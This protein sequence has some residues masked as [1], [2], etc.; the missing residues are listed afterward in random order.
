MLALPRPG[1]AAAGCAE[2]A[3]EP[4]PFPGPAFAEQAQA[5]SVAPRRPSL[6][7][8]RGWGYDF[9]YTID[10]RPEVV[11]G[12]GYNPRFAAL[13][14][15]QRRARYER[16]FG[17]MAALGV[18]TVFGWDPSQFDELTL[19]VAQRWGLG[20]AMP[21]DFD[22]KRD[23]DD[24]GVRRTLTEQVTGW[25]A[26]YRDHP[27]VRMWAIGNETFHKL[28]P[29]AWCREPPTAGQSARARAFGRF[30]AGL[31]QQVHL[32]DP[33]HPVLYREAEDSY[34]GWMKGALASDGPRPWFVYGVNVYT[35]RITEIVR[36]WPRHGF[37]SAMLVSEFAPGREDRP[38]G[39]VDYWAAIRQYPEQVLG[40][41][42]YV[43][44]AEGPEKGDLAF[45]LVDA[46]GHHIDGSL[47]MI[48]SVYRADGGQRPPSGQ[49]IVATCRQ[50]GAC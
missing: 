39:Y 5:G 46:D 4:L 45:G 28:V 43:W 17:R 13:E 19:D 50:R 1:L 41:S 24:P 34:V 16:D 11:R 20:V 12:M 40:G 44:Y 37:D 6:T 33:N 18:N 38:G 25:V 7:S 14:P 32:A 10:G 21:F 49:S 27:A 47:G 30:Y 35:P 29:P 22:W 2:L 48:G 26:R 42:V 36:R 9:R 8:V 3:L 23:Y 31:I 15:A